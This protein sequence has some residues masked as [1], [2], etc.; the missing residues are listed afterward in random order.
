MAAIK[1]DAQD[2]AMLINSF[3]RGCDNM[4][5]K[6]KQLIRLVDSLEG[7]ETKHKAQLLEK[8]D[9]AK[10]LINKSIE[11]IEAEKAIVNK[12]REY[13]IANEA[14]NPFASIEA[15]APKANIADLC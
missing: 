15:D 1:F 14:V 6:S 11:V 9:E 4:V 13:L 8:L 7:Y 5:T 2:Q 3:S 10:K 12:K